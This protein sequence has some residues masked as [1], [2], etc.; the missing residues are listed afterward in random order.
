[1]AEALLPFISDKHL[2]LLSPV[3]VYWAYSF[4]FYVLDEWHP[5]WLEAYRIHTPE[6]L[7]TRNRVSKAAVARDV[8]IQHGIQ[9]VIG[10]AVLGNDAERPSTSYIYSLARLFT[11]FVLLD[12]WQYCWHRYMHVNKYLYR[13]LHSRHHR[14]YVPYAFGA[15]YNHPI[16]GL[17][18]DTLGSGLAHMVCGLSTREAI[19]F[20]CLSTAKTVDDHCGYVLPWDPLQ[21]IFHNNAKYHDIHHQSFGFTKNY[22]QPYFV[23]WDRWCGTM[24]EPPSESVQNDVVRPSNDHGA[25]AVKSTTTPLTKKTVDEKTVR[26]RLASAAPVVIRDS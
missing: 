13:T 25:I 16:E 2:A 23:V 15:L 5:Q 19:V 10:M 14:L 21:F 18:M 11:A 1:M 24:Y 6:E 9:T 12:T 22:S 17:I 3:V 4:V 8:L 26:S 20:F 7:A